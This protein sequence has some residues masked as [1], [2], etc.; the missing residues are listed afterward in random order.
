LVSRALQEDWQVTVKDEVHEIL[1]PNSGEL[2][3]AIVR[4]RSSKGENPQ[5]RRIDFS[6]PKEFLQG[7]HI[8]IPANYS[9]QPHI[10]NERAREF[11]NLR[12][13]ETWVVMSG[14]VEVDYFS[15]SGELIHSATLLS[16][17]VSITFRGGHGYRTRQTSARVFEFKSGPYEGQEI[18]KRFIS[19]E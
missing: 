7:A 14:A 11:S 5:L 2:L 18:D 10:H 9:F 19:N 17:D 12:A 16:G 1:D 6:D 8:D 13:Q 4:P 15:E 3:H